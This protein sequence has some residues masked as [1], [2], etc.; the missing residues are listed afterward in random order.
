M[1]R[2]VVALGSNIDPDQNIQKAREILAQKYRVLAESRF[3]T[4]QP[5]GRVDQPDFVNGAVL[6]A[7]SSSVEQLKA[8]LKGIESGLGRRAAH[9]Q[10][11][12]RTIDLDVVVWN[13][14]V[15]DRD[16]YERDYLKRS[17]LEV[18]PELK[19]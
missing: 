15:I 10:A 6:L 13:M 4:T 5:V 3:E 17:V 1:N 19:Y 7:T 9:D 12:P 2:A 16:F 8:A 11:G 14:R 18:V